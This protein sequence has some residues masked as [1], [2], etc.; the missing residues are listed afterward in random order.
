MRWIVAVLALV[1]VFSTVS[2]SA[3]GDEDI[4]RLQ[5]QLRAAGYYP[6]PLDGLPGPQTLS[7]LRNFRADA[8]GP[9]RLFSDDGEYVGDLSANPY[10]PNS[11]SNPF[12]IYGSELSPKSINN[13]LPLGWR[14]TLCPGPD[15][16][17]PRGLSLSGL[18]VN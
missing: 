12:G 7:A 4:L 13:S 15:W 10:A 14:E 8:S 6:G 16:R 18:S 9:P 2:S 11:T 17:K 3:A 5:I 1:L